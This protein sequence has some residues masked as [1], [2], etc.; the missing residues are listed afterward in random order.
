MYKITKEFSFCASHVLN[1]LPA[2]HPCSRLHGH[3]YVVVIELESIELDKTGMV[4]DY[5]KFHLFKDFI[6]EHLDHQHLNDMAK[7]NPTADF[8][9]TAENL[10]KYLFNIFKKTYPQLAAVIVKED[11]TR[12][13]RYSPEF[14]TKELNTRDIA[15]KINDNML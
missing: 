11:L 1:N 12:S 10:A 4:I 2:G 13:V 15:K 14:E 3:N 9:P 8:N 7:F 6:D 5:R